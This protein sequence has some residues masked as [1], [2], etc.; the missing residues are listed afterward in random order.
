MLVYLLA[1]LS[2]R[3]R[4]TVQRWMA[5]SPAAGDRELDE[6]CHVWDGEARARVALHEG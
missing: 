3:F 6:I 2:E 1:K 5:T 4:M